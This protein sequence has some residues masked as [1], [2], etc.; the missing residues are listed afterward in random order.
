MGADRK[1][2]LLD[3]IFKKKVYYAFSENYKALRG[4][5]KLLGYA[6]YN[7]S[8]LAVIKRK[9]GGIILRDEK[10]INFR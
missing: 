2:K 5:G 10:F 3:R 4:V 6:Y 8:K 9:D 1:M 7:K